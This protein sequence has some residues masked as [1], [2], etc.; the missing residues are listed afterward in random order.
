MKSLPGLKR[1]LHDNL[2][3]E[4]ES[5]DEYV[6]SNCMR[7]SKRRQIYSADICVDCEK[8]A[9]WS[10]ADDCME[11]AKHNSPLGCSRSPCAVEGCLSKGFAGLFSGRPCL[12]LNRN[13]G[14]S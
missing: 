12:Q 4:H 10:A 7:P 5:L 11:I 3:N 6:K 13:R 14:V 2:Q 1:K 8:N 9:S